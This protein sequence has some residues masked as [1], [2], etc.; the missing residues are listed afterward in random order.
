MLLTLKRNRGRGELF[1][2][3]HPN[4]AVRYFPP[5]LYEHADVDTTYGIHLSLIDTSA[6]APSDL[7]PSPS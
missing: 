7:I 4:E 6:I 1:P 2:K 3:Q 5:S